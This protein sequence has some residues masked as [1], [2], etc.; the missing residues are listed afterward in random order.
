ML[1]WEILVKQLIISFEEIRGIHAMKKIFKVLF[2]SLLF[3]G[4]A[5]CGGGDSSSEDNAADVTVTTPDGVAVTFASDEATV[6]EVFELFFNLGGDQLTGTIFW[7]DNTTTRVRGSG[8]ASHIYRGSGTVTIAIQIDGQA[9]EGVA[10]ITVLPATPVE[11]STESVSSP[12]TAAPA[13][14]PTAATLSIPTCTA[15]F[16]EAGG[17][18]IGNIQF[19]SFSGQVVSTD[20]TADLSGTEVEVIGR[21]NSTTG[22]VDFVTLGSVITDANGN[23]SRT[24]RFQSIVDFPNE[25]FA[26]VQ[27]FFG[28]TPFNSFSFD[29]SIS[30]CDSTDTDLEQSVVIATFP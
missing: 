17:S 28:F 20:A 16:V 29:A 27:T 14:T 22:T 1:T 7:G 5:A 12:T 15:D 3:A 23:F 10:N 2:V 13:V 6:N 30:E 4:I 11:Q 8:T 19:N 9:A 24:N 25:Q 26:S 21:I 18:G